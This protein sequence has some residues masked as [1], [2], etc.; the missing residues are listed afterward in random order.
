MAKKAVHIGVLSLFVLSLLAPVAF[1]ADNPFQVLYDVLWWIPEKIAQGKISPGSEGDFNARFLL[2]IFVYAILYFA[3]THVFSGASK[4][5]L[6]AVP[7]SL[8]ILGV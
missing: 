2:F 3:A 6:V 1:A 5:V 8:S 7:M 4:G